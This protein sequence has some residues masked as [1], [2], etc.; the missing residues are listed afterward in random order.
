MDF[1]GE[2][3]KSKLSFEE[4]KI[5]KDEW[6]ENAISLQKHI[7]SKTINDKTTIF[8]TYTFTLDDGS[9]VVKTKEFYEKAK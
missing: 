3:G 8:L 6:P 4:Y 5:E 1:F 7:E 9:S 2:S